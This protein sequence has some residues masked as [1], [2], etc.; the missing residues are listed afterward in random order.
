MSSVLTLTFSGVGVADENIDVTGGGVIETFKASR[1]TNKQ[2]PVA[3]D[4]AGQVK[5]WFDAFNT[6]Y[7]INNDYIMTFDT[8]TVT[9][10]HKSDTHFDSLTKTATNITTGVTTK[11]PTP[12]FTLTTETYGEVTTNKCDEVQMNLTF[13]E[14]FGGTIDG[15]VVKRLVSLGGSETE[16][17]NNSSHNSNTLQLDIDREVHIYTTITVNIGA[18]SKIFSLACP[19][20]KLEIT[21]VEVGVAPFSHDVTIFINSFIGSD[22]TQFA[23]PT[24]GGSPTYQD[25]NVFS[26]VLPG[27]YNAYAKDK[28]GCE[29]IA[30]VEVGELENGVNNSKL[31]ISK[32]NSHYFADR[33]SA[34]VLSSNIHNWLSFDDPYPV[35][36]RNFKQV[37]AANQIVTNQFKSDYAR[38]TATLTTRCETNPTSV[39]LTITKRTDNVARDTYL[40]G[41]ISSDSSTNSMRISFTPGDIYDS[42]LTTVIGSHTYDEVLPDFYEEGMFVRI[43]GY[44]G[45]VILIY[46]ENDI[47]YARTNIHYTGNSTT[48]AIHSIHEELDYEIYEFDVSHTGMEGQ[49][50]MIELKAYVN[51]TTTTESEYFVSEISKVVSFDDFT[52]MNYHRFR[53]WSDY[54]DEEIDYTDWDPFAQKLTDDDDMPTNFIRHE[55]NVKFDEPLFP[56]SNAEI[57]GE[58]LDE[59]YVKLDSQTNSIWDTFFTRVP[60]LYAKSLAKLFDESNYIECDGVLFTTNTQAEIE[61]K[62][63]YGVVKPKLIEIG[64]SNETNRVNKSIKRFYPVKV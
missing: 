63:Q 5:R 37:W 56:L 64:G 23:L 13:T 53:F 32:K 19:Q 29:K 57:Q 1:T 21:E 60:A 20:E 39:D 8:T 34:N 4:T 54:T 27:Q 15:M 41:Q 18:E 45:K 12:N 52:K 48:T 25:T 33:K 22:E 6:D 62:G 40:E 35:K 24:V 47:V 17:Y 59:Q 46:T 11:T 61:K 44:D 43:D 31:F 38:H 3:S 55:R 36:A 14:E 50:Y 10:E 51:A 2:V 49:E 9:L 30:N 28:Y 7:N 16:L 58:K 26:G 42:D